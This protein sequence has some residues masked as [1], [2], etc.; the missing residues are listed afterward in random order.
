MVVV[1]VIDDVLVIPLVKDL[2][3]ACVLVPVPRSL[4]VDDKY[5]KKI[6][7]FYYFLHKWVRINLDL[8]RQEAAL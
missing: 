3:A 6:N 7:E 2:D 1:P 5:T 8:A 4:L